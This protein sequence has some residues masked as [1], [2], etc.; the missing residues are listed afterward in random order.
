MLCN[1][2][3]LTDVVLLA[4]ATVPTFL[5]AVASSFGTVQQKGTVMGI[6]RSLGA[7]ARAFG[8]VVASF[9]KHISHSD[10]GYRHCATYSHCCKV[11]EI[12][13]FEITY[14]K[15]TLFHK[16]TNGT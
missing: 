13:V 9:G 10:S 7:L 6:F 8:P 3:W 5:T 12:L 2:P 14:L 15:Y 4:A 11:I 1:V 16:K